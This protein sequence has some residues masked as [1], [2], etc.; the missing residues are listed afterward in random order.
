MVGTVP[1]YLDVMH[2]PRG[3]RGALAQSD[4]DEERSRENVAVLGA[5][6]AEDP[7]PHREPHRPGTIQAGR[8]MRF[9][10][11]GVLEGVGRAA[12]PGGV[13]IDECVFIAV[14][15]HD[16]APVRRRDPRRRSTGSDERTRV[17]LTEIKVELGS[18]E[19][20]LPAALLLGR[21]AATSAERPQDD[22]KLD[23][24]ARAA[25]PEGGARRGSST[26]SSARSPSSRSSSAASGS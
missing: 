23:R 22:V 1:E 21:H 3:R 16:E 2:E 20:V 6:A 4:V 11:V 15:L 7:L 9:S 18:T 10:V 5:S 24:P 26:S 19:E 14:H 8:S 17:E 12:S 25:T 13:P